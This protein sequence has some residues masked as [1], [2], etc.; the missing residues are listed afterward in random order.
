M[1]FPTFQKFEKTAVLNRKVEDNMDTFD[2]VNDISGLF[3]YK[4]KMERKSCFC[5]FMRS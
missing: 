1:Y 4:I 2:E 3:T 5:K